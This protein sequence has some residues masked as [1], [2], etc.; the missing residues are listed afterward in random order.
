MLQAHSMKQHSHRQLYRTSAWCNVMPEQHGSRN[1]AMSMPAPY[2]VSY[3]GD[4]QFGRP[5]YA[6]YESHYRPGAPHVRPAY[7]MREQSHPWQQQESYAAAIKRPLES[8][9]TGSTRQIDSYTTMASRPM[10]SYPTP[11]KQR[12]DAYTPTGDV[13]S[14]SVH[15][16]DMKP[17]ATNHGRYRFILI[18]RKFSV[19][20]N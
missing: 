7:G 12:I 6:H 20:N 10:E 16:P 4:K 2:D 17:A 18:C 3:G 1:P 8:Y 9:T 14:T 11:G 5:N 13:G 15:L 19:S